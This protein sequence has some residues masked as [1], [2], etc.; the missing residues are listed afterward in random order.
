MSERT[1]PACGGA[2]LNARARSVRIAGKAIWQITALSVKEALGRFASLEERLVRNS[3]DKERLVLEKTQK[4]IHHKLR[5]LDEVGLGYLTLDRRANSLSGGE[6]QRVRLAAQLGSNLRG[7]C[8]ILDE[9]TIGLHTRDNHRLLATLRRAGGGGQYGSGGGARRGHHPGGRRAWWTWDPAPA[10]A[11]GGWW[12]WARRTRWCGQPGLG[13]R[14]VPGHL[15]PAVVAGADAQERRLADGDRRPGEQPQE[16]E[17]APAPGHVDLRHRRVRLGQEHAGEG[18]A[19][20]GAQGEA[21]AKRGDGRANTRTW[22]AGKLIERAR[23][24]GPDP[25]RQDPAPPYPASY[26]GVPGRDP[27]HLRAASRGAHARLHAEPVLLQR[28]RGPLRRVRRPGPDPQG[29]ELPS[30]RVRQLRRLRRPAFQRRDPRRC[31]STARTS[32]R[33][34]G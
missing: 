28:E 12:P 22:P 26:V 16:P 27:P 32:R 6:A 25:H 5:F 20:Q 30:R 31:G 8:Y 1:C 10:C 13:H 18:S 9:P 33:C 11:A 23:G 34:C 21:G 3:A 4:E 24:G 17:G 7:V 14:R 29:N 15:P 19:F 2:R